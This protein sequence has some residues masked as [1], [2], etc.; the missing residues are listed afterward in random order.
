MSSDSQPGD[1]FAAS[2]IRA[3]ASG[4]AGL[5]AEAVCAQDPG[6]ADHP[7]IGGLAGLQ[8]KL[9]TRLTYLATA[10]T[11]SR[12]QMFSDSIAWTRLAWEARGIPSEF[13][14]KTLRL[15]GSTVGSKLPPEAKRAAEWLEHA[16]NDLGVVE[17]E[18]P[19]HI[20]LERPNGRLAAEYFL[21]L[22]EGNRRVA[23]DQVLAAV[24]DGLSPTSQP[25]PTSCRTGSTTSV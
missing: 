12:S 9:E 23:I 15:L 5:T 25:R 8:S 7:A 4:L 14:A 1:Q 10:L 6:F 11:H 20:S 2:L 21:N 13:L 24:D 18:I 19:S 17:G 16:A 3:S 22:L